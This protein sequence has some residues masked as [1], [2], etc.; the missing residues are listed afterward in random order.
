MA[1]Y[2]L[3]KLA[4]EDLKRIHQYG[5]KKFGTAQADKYFFNFFERFEEIAQ[6][7]FSF[8]DVSHIAPGYRRCV[9][10]A[11]AIYFRVGKEFIEVMAIIGRQ[12][13][14]L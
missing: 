1:N 4:E 11:D 5:T 13:F 10:G 12:D 2:K 9:S 7:P 6:R 14:Q 3:S 8:E